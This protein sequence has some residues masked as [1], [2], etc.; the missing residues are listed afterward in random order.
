MKILYLKI[1]G[2]FKKKHVLCFIHFVP[3]LLELKHI[4]YVKLLFF[5]VYKGISM[6]NPMDLI[7]QCIHYFNIISKL[8]FQ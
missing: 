7:I 5:E 4:M 6:Y 3:L 8:H 2:H 1:K